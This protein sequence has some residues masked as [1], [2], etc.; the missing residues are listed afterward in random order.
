MQLVD[1]GLRVSLLIRADDFNDSFH[2]EHRAV[3]RMSFLKPIG[4]DQDQFSRLQLDSISL[5]GS[6]N[7][8][9]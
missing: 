1:D 2:A 3:G 9:D 7:L 5:R 4:R 8:V 6:R